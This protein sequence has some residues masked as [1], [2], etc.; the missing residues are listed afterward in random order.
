MNGSIYAEALHVIQQIYGENAS[1][2][3]GQYE[4]VE[5]TLTHRRTL[6]IQKTGWGKSL[7]YFVCAKL[8]R[9]AGKGMTIVVSPLLVLMENQ[10]QSAQQLGLQ[11]AVLNSSTKAQRKEH[12]VA[13]VNGDLDLVLITPE[14]LFTEKV[15]TA[16][17]QV[18]IGL[19]VIDEA[20]CIS[21]WGHD[22][23]LEYTRLNK[24]IRQ[25][26]HTV[27]ILGTTATANNRV[28]A[29]LKEQFGEDVFI[30]RGEL[31]RHSL[32]IQI[33][34]LST[35]AER[36]AWILENVP[37]LS[38]S[39]IIYCLTQRD[40]EHLAGFLQ[41]NGISALAYHSGM[42]QNDT[43]H[44]ESLLRNDQIKVLVATVKLG[45]GYDKGDIAFVIH[46]QQ[47]SN[48]VAYYQQIGRAGRNI[49]RAY[50]FL[51]CGEE[52]R[53]I[54][55]Y[56]IETAFPSEEEA[57]NVYDIIY[58]Y[59]E[60]GISRNGIQSQINIRTN[61]LEKALMFL[62]N[63]EFIVKEGTKY[64]PTLHSFQY[65]SEHY[66]AVTQIRR[67]EQQQMSEL[68]DTTQCLS[69]FIVNR[70][71]DPTTEK[72]GICRNCLG[73]PEF[74][75]YP[76]QQYIE[77]AL[78]YIERLQIPITPRKNWADTSF[79]GSIRI[80][81]PNAEGICLS[82]Y[83]DP[84][85]GALVKKGKYSNSAEFCEELIGKSASV[86]RPIIAEKGITAITCVPSLRSRI[87]ENFAVSLAKRC[88]IPFVPMLKK[89]GRI[90]QK[91]M[92]NSVY[93][94]RNAWNS[95]S[96]Q[97][98]IEDIPTRIILVDDIIDSKWTMTVCGYLLTM[99]GCEMVFPFALA[100]SSENRGNQE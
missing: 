62:R 94:C 25:M 17:R 52:D 86:L 96:L 79:T 31:M 89:N 58:S 64:Y 78:D 18:Q 100:D 69:R 13:M 4:A 65:N 61:R 60:S 2:R 70:L 92:E 84:G 21:D 83:G 35:A 36:Y 75:E 10:I 28:I 47:P 42:E 53:N 63:E 85:Y 15:Q 48:I 50:T 26:P 39:G 27:P 49:D 98:N 81:A 97:D 57:R 80:T 24:I 68:S 41:E 32:S 73:Y 20:H 93:Q 30:S 99:A 76:S 82:K 40:C 43:E 77:N 51:M 19:F 88:R 45:M 74:P 7:V 5:A 91:N 38:G 33:L 44:A 1:F 46:Y 11:C 14:T 59:A 12:L 6:V 34:H 90:Q 22:F 55:N 56:F 23:R 72:C 8:Q 54:Q 16:L 71:D 87:V 66:D 3:E 95:F 37:R 9:N 29:D 67:Q